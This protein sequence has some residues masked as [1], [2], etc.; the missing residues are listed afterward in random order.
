MKHPLREQKQDLVGAQLAF[1]E[2][3]LNLPVII[4]WKDSVINQWIDRE[5]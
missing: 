5:E 2:I 1:L 4:N 3:Q